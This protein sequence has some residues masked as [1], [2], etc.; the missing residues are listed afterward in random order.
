MHLS[1]E[2]ILWIQYFYSFWII[3]ICAF[4]LVSSALSATPDFPVQAYLQRLAFKISTCLFTC[5]CER[6][7]ALYLTSFPAFCI[8]STPI[9][10]SLSHRCSSSPFLAILPTNHQNFMESMW[11][12]EKQSTAIE[13][14]LNFSHVHLLPLMFIPEA[15]LQPT[16]PYQFWQITPHKQIQ[17]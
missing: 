9:L 12:V 6:L 3:F 10:L 17:T 13:I 2:S 16:L 8:F 14:C 7:A 11:N 5:F 15:A 4:I 1:G